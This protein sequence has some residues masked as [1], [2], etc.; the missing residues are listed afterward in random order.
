MG[1]TLNP[2]S[3]SFRTLQAEHSKLNDLQTK[4]LN[5]KSLTLHHEPQYCSGLEIEFRGTTLD[6][7]PKPGAL[8]PQQNPTKPL[9]QP[10]PSDVT[11]SGVSIKKPSELR[12]ANSDVVSALFLFGRASPQIK[13]TRSGCPVGFL[14]PGLGSEK[15]KD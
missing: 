4:S 7:N 8:K 14:G 11:T 6:I 5:P 15:K 10:F 3:R 1:Y 2:T 13:G 12:W 9:Q